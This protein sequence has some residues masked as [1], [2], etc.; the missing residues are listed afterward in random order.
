MEFLMKFI[1]AL[2]S[3]NLRMSGLRSSASLS[4]A[5]HLF[6]LLAFTLLIQRQA[7]PKAAQR[8][9]YIDLEP[10][11]KDI[12]KKAE[13]P[14]EKR[15]VQTT[16]AAKSATAA[17]DAYLGEQTQT[18]DRQTV[19]RERQI[20]MGQAS[21]TLPQHQATPQQENRKASK[22]VK[23]LATK[24]AIIPLQNLGLPI[25]PSAKKMEEMA[26]EKTKSRVGDEFVTPSEQAPQDYI[27]GMKEGEATALNTREFMFYGYY[28]RIRER[29]DRAWVP[30]L[31]ANVVSLYN[32]GRRLASEMD[33]A[34]K[35][36][37]VMNSGG[38]IIKIQV[39][40][41]SGTSDLDDAAVA[42]FNK[43]G[44]FPNPPHGIVDAAGEIKIPWEFVLRT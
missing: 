38:E 42:A 19:S 23:S 39:L 35:I 17:P 7:P 6:F 44:P 43:A 28:Q 26:Q 2:P 8:T 1:S 11:H 3:L 22:A 20:Q 9:T 5:V 15:I 32:H 29:L 31:R 4:I 14:P 21:Q 25:L 18:V 27:K 13:A 30:L 41:E 33:Y 34:T 16:K 24:P 12:S 36:M 37:V 10:Y 40:T